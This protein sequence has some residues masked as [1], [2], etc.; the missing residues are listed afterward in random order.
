VAVEVHYNFYNFNCS[1]Y[2]QF[3]DDVETTFNCSHGSGSFFEA[4]SGYWGTLYGSVGL[5]G[6]SRSCFNKV[7]PSNWVLMVVYEIVLYDAD[8]MTSIKSKKTDFYDESSE[9]DLIM[10]TLNKFDPLGLIFEEVTVSVIEIISTDTIVHYDCGVY[11]YCDEHKFQDSENRI[12][13]CESRFGN[14][15]GDFCGINSNSSEHPICFANTWELVGDTKL[16]ACAHDGIE[17]DYWYKAGNFSETDCQ[18][19]AD[20]RPTSFG[21]SYTFE[22]ISAQCRLYVAGNK[23]LRPEGWSFSAKEYSC[24]TSTNCITGVSTGWLDDWT[25]SCYVRSHLSVTYVYYGKALATW[26]HI[27][28][29]L[30]V[31]ILIII[32]LSRLT[33]RRSDRNIFSRGVSKADK[34]VESLVGLSTKSVPEDLVEDQLQGFPKITYS[35]LKVA[36]IVGEGSF[37]QVLRSVY[38]D[39]EST[40]EYALKM[41]IDSNEESFQNL[42]NEIRVA[43]NISSNPHVITM[44]GWTRD[45]VGNVGIVLPFYKLGSLMEH[46]YGWRTNQT[47][48]K[49]LKFNMLAKFDLI[50]DIAQGIQHLHNEN[51]IHGDIATRN[52]LLYEDHRVHCVITDFGMSTYKLG[53]GDEDSAAIRGRKGPL[54]WMPRETILSGEY[55]TASDVYA[56]AI[57]CWE[58]L[59]EKLPYSD[60]NPRQAALSANKGQRPPLSK[61]S[62]NYDGRTLLNGQLHLTSSQEFGFTSSMNQRGWD[63]LLKQGTEYFP[64]MH[65]N[66]IGHSQ[67]H[68]PGSRKPSIFSLYTRNL[69][70]QA[71]VPGPNLCQLTDTYTLGNPNQLHAINQGITHTLE[72]MIE[73]CWS[74]KSEDRPVISEVVDGLNDIQTL[75]HLDSQADQYDAVYNSNREY[76]GFNSD[77]K[78]QSFFQ[79]AKTLRQK[80]SLWS[81]TEKR[82]KRAT[83]AVQQTGIWSKRRYKSHRGSDFAG[84]LTSRIHTLRDLNPADLAEIPT[85]VSI[86]KDVQIAHETSPPLFLSAISTE[87]STHPGANLEEGNET[88][89]VVD[90]MAEAHQASQDS[91][92]ANIET[93]EECKND[94]VSAILQNLSDT[95]K[96]YHESI[97]LIEYKDADSSPTYNQ[98]KLIHK[99]LLRV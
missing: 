5:E 68:A 38:Q 62:V 96:M 74:A 84:Q 73:N 86:A 58:I 44:I 12:C 20:E 54:R 71:S 99:T 36:A 21:Y 34:S 49:C 25:A 27:L 66:D 41:L 24:N 3:H 76:T 90:E 88:L 60:L 39:E 75:L 43:Y 63:L 47:E 16:G 82:E 67:N 81:K 22:G 94:S 33:L 40:Y 50:R 23:L 13:T 83:L 59:N 57:T 69:L 51:I 64:D 8:T 30:C 55:T 42:L 32:F 95:K 37:G 45:D 93:N 6:V 92:I 7:P 29:T 91:I 28:S 46:L 85:K 80:L 78:N 11:Y 26:V 53:C 15:T 17:V 1:L 2:T 14:V 9:K 4:T 72:L 10:D 77:E 56:F 61:D 89:D 97:S 70:E 31:A 19:Y 65:I 18:R 87:S 35:K 98:Q 48:A 52:V 79:K